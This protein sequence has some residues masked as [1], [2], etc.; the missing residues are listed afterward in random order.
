MA[1]QMNELVQNSYSKADDIVR[2]AAGQKKITSA[3]VATFGSVK[4]IAD[5]LLELSRIDK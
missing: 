3:T 5:E 4:T 1:Q 2:E